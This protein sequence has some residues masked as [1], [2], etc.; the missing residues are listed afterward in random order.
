MS[1]R[2][3]SSDSVSS[4]KTVSLLLNVNALA[5]YPQKALGLA[6]GSLLPNSLADQTA[7]WAGIFPQRQWL[8]CRP[9]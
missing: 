9:L 8:I 4:F 6:L 2:A 1:A 3:S 7:V 5:G